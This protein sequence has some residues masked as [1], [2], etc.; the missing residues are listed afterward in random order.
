[1]AFVV[2]SQDGFDELYQ[3]LLR[4]PPIA[5]SSDEEEDE[6]VGQGDIRGGGDG[7]NNR[8]GAGQDHA[9]VAA[10][11]DSRDTRGGAGV[12]G[13][14]RDTR[15]GAEVA[16]HSR[17][18]R[19]GAEVAE[20]DPIEEASLPPPD[21]IEATPA[22]RDQQRLARSRTSRPTKWGRCERCGA[23]MRVVYPTAPGA[24]AFLGCINFR[25]RF[26]NSCRFTRTVPPDRHHELS[27]R[28]VVRLN[29]QD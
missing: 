25:S 18:T 11:V 22:D 12:A 14:S 20:A 29:M 23:P 15:G 26:Q 4:C 1:M 8:A 10:V 13:H 28:V 7:K 3:D 21:P 2:A 9:S 19:G 5:I 17:D 27:D 16:G 24:S 6:E